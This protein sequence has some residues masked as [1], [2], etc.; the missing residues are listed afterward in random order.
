ME[1]LKD[2]LGVIVNSGFLHVF[3]SSVINKFIAFLSNVVLVRILS[4]PEYGVFTYAWNIYSLL[5]L[6]GGMGI[7]YGILQL[8]S[9]HSG[10]EEYAER[11]LNYGT[12]FGVVFDL[13]LVAII[14]FVGLF[15]PLKIEASRPL[16]IALSALPLLELFFEIMTAYLRGQKKHKEYSR[17]VVLNTSVLFISSAVCALFFRSF[18][19]VIGYYAA[20]L[21]SFLFGTFILR[22]RLI[23]SKLPVFDDKSAILK[24]SVTSMLNNASTI[25]MYLLDVFVLG[26]IIPQESILASYKVAT[27]IPTALT[28]IP[29][30][31]F[32]YFYPYF[33]EKKDDREWCLKRFKQILLWFGAF[34]LVLSAVLVIFAPWIISLLYGP[35]YLD[36][37]M[38][39]RIL[40]V[41]YFFSST[42]RFVAV[43]ILIT[44]RKLKF[45]FAVSIIITVLNVI[46]DY[47][48]IQWWGTTGAA[49]AT[50]SV[51][52]LAGILSTVY[53]VYTLKKTNSVSA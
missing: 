11:A 31:L 7:S 12:R 36:Q 25:L 3:G 20:Y 53:L 29:L 4:K 10:D 2:R 45:N 51:D 35:Q 18:G 38:V 41:N 30:T 5:F 40:T 33:A 23:R 48:F 46:A 42:F 34:N 24:I 47:F 19:L 14:L 39:F 17:L 28:F 26:I 44:Q 21:I 43:N 49:V 50:L 16:L 37:L 22:I 32:T 1:R 15:V 9:E 27:L 6:L 8:T 13:F 52:L